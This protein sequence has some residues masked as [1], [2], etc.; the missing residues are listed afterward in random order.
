MPEVG[1]A[2][3]A[4][5][6]FRMQSVPKMGEVSGRINCDNSQI[7]VLDGIRPGT[8]LRLDCASYLIVD[9]SDAGALRISL[10]G[11]PTI[12]L[13]PDGQRLSSR[14]IAVRRAEGNGD[15]P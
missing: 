8:R 15:S 11:R 5:K 4:F 9:A 14:Y 1:I 3:N 7:E 10:P 12:S 6:I 13:G 2:E